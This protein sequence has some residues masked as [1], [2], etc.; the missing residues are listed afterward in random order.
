[1]YGKGVAVGVQTLQVNVLQ[2]K[3]V[4]DAGVAAVFQLLCQHAFHGGIVTLAVAI[5]QAAVG[6]AQWLTIQVNGL[7]LPRG[8]GNGHFQNGL[9]TQHHFL[10][11][12]IGQQVDADFSG[13]VQVVEQV[14]PHLG[15]IGQPGYRKHPGFLAHTQQHHTTMR[16]GHGRVGGPEIFGHFALSILPFREL[17]F[18]FVGL[19]QR[20]QIIQRVDVEH[21]Q[22]SSIRCGTSGN[23]IG[24]TASVGSP[25]ALS[26]GDFM[27]G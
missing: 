1:M 11:V 23:G 3:A 26:G 25:W 27:A 24:A 7:L 12:G 2:T 8:R 17:A 4:E 13:V 22:T 6:V 19:A 10:H 18:E 21:Q 14:G 16:I 15:R 9:T 20:G 5:V